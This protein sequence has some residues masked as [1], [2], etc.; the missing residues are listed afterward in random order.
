MTYFNPVY[1]Y[2]VAEFVRDAKTAG[3]DGVIV[4]DLP[5]EEAAELIRESKLHDFKDVFF[6]SPTSS[7]ER[8]RSV[9]QSATGFI[10]YVS[11]T[12]VTGARRHIPAQIAQNVR[13]IKRLTDKPVCVG[14]G[15]STPA[16]ARAIAGIADGVIVG[17]AVIKVIEKHACSNDATEAV[18]RFASSLLEQVRRAR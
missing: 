5:P 10:Y 13:L 8:M 14:F 6:L 11:L 3:A 1:H 9:S 18:G 2:G 12:G 4:P 7:L 16:Q 17:S 15:I